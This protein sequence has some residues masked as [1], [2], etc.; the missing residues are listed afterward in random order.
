MATVELDIVRSDEAEKALL[1]CL[2]AYPEQIDEV[3]PFLEVDDFY[4]DTNKEIYEAIL[5][6]P[7]VLREDMLGEVTRVKS[8]LREAMKQEENAWMQRC[9]IWKQKLV[10]AEDQ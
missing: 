7:G 5:P 3:V 8:N 6:L 1:G 2:M 4:S 9:K 10:K